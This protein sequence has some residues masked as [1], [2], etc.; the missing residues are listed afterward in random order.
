[1]AQYKAAYSAQQA[2]CLCT[3]ALDRNVVGN[4]KMYQY[5]IAGGISKARPH[6]PPLKLKHQCVCASSNP[7]SIVT[8]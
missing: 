7:S 3:K 8:P 2:T 4:R 5:E 1:M 6:P